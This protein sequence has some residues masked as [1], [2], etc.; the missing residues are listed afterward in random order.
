MAGPTIEMLN[1][2]R[3]GASAIDR[4]LDQLVAAK[5]VDLS[6][7]MWLGDAARNFADQADTLAVLLE[8]RSGDEDLH[9]EAEQLAIFF[10]SIEQRLEIALGTAWV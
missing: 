5:T 7:L 3:K 1:T 6:A 10:R 4:S 2:L 8:V 9:D